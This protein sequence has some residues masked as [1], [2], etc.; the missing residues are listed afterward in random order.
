MNIIPD[1]GFASNKTYPY[2]RLVSTEI[3]EDVDP[4]RKEDY[5]SDVEFQQ[6]LGVTRKSFQANP[7]WKQVNMKKKSGLF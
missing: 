3:P 5:L 6:Y 2:E 7:T 4:T 1:L